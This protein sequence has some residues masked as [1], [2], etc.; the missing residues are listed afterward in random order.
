MPQRFIDD[1][2]S[3]D[4]NEDIDKLSALAWLISILPGRRIPISAEALRE[5]LFPRGGR[6]GLGHASTAF[7]PACFRCA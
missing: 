6:G 7:A 3:P 2:Y 5:L 4:F 1:C